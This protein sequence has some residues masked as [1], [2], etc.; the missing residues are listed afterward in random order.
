M[1]IADSAKAKERMSEV[2]ED[3][4][5]PEHLIRGC[6]LALDRDLHLPAGWLFCLSGGRF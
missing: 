3:A 5:A 2:T 6:R 1:K 4:A